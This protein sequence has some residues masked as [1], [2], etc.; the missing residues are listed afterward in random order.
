MSMTAYNIAG[1]NYVKLRDI[2]QE[3]GFNVYWQDGVQ[4]DT[5]APYTGEVNIPDGEV[6]T[7]PVRDSVNGTIRYNAPSLYQGVT[8]E[9]VSFTFE[10][11][12][13]IEASANENE[14]LTELL[15]VRLLPFIL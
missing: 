14:K 4:I 11:G 10:N 8:Y 2:G 5:D 9:N 1:S 7:A 12:R 3:I 15:I 6:F 13:I